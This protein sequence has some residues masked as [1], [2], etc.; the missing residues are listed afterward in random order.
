MSAKFQG[1]YLDPLITAQSM[2]A[3]F[4]GTPYNIETKDNVG[5]QLKWTGASPGGTINVQVSID[6]NPQFGTGTWTLL[7]DASGNPIVITPGGAAGTG[8]FSL[9]QLEA[10]WVQVVYT[11]A[12]GSVGLLTA[13][14]VA[15]AM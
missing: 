8:Y 10:P 11:T 4:N 13:K 1:P 15:K 14:Y 7:D 6:Y 9:N 12:G 5:L 2:A 3:S